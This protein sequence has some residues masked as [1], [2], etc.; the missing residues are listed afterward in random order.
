[1]NER[2][3]VDNFI[4]LKSLKKPEKQFINGD[5]HIINTYE[6]RGCGYHKRLFCASRI[7]KQKFTK[8]L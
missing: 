6:H 4:H 3:Y 2:G 5:I 8:N 1:M 7:K